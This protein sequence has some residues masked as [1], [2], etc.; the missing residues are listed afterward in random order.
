MDN[1]LLYNIIE[2]TDFIV[3]F[4]FLC[5]VSY[6]LIFSIASLKSQK[7]IYRK[8]KRQ[9]RFLIIFTAYEIDKRI[10]DSIDAFSKQ[11]YPK[12]NFDLVIISK[13]ISESARHLLENAPVVL[14]KS[15]SNQHFRAEMIESAI[16][17]MDSN[18]DEIVIMNHG[19]TVE[20]NF[21][22]EINNAFYAGGM[23]LQTH[24]ILNNPQTNTSILNA[25]SEEINN[26]IFR[27]GH[28]RL[29]L[30]SGLNGSGMA[31]HYAW[32]KKYIGKIRQTS[33]TKEL[34]ILLLRQGIFIQYLENIYTYDQKPDSISEFNKQ[35]QNW[36]TAKRFTLKDATKDFPKA[37]MAGNFDYCNKIFQWIMPSKFILLFL[38]CIAAFIMIIVKWSLSIKW[39]LLLIVLLLVFD[40]ATPSKLRNLRS[41]L[42]LI[43]FPV[44]FLSTLMNALRIRIR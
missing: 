15:A 1:N 34:E 20:P 36:Y 8:A 26:S 2:W 37:L 5:S 32:F 44:L 10:Q 40:L 16:N 4:L 3:Y 38:I 11:T 42:A 18:Y 14:M 33:L 28:V 23:A 7:I 43:A 13:I 19:N 6:L 41:I 29:G 17:E 35:R 39:F 24:R 12:S 22:E 30:S 25:I 9:H 27:R 21:L 31:F